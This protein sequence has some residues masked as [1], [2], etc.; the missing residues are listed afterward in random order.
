MAVNMKGYNNNKD[1]TNAG[2]GNGLGLGGNPQYDTRPGTL[3][4]SKDSDAF[5]PTNELIKDDFLRMMEIE[6]GENNV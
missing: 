2:A 5:A 3:N 4:D 6:E 1:E